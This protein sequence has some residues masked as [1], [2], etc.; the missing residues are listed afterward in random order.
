VKVNRWD[1][2]GGICGAFVGALALAFWATDAFH[3]RDTVCVRNCLDLLVRGRTQRFY[4]VQYQWEIIILWALA[5]VVLG[6]FGG[7]L[8]VSLLRYLRRTSN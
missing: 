8:A 1:V 2:A 3:L 7:V 6:V 4:V 5:G